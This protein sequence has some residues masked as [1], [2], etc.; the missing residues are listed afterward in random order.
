[1]RNK[2]RGLA[3]IAARNETKRI[4]IMCIVPQKGG[5]RK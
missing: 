1:M 4:V 2:K 5:V 3:R